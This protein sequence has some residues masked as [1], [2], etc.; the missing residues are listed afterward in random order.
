M[1]QICFV[2]KDPCPESVSLTKYICMTVV[3]FAPLNELPAYTG[4]GFE[5]PQLW[6]YFSTRNRL[7]ETI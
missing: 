6:R 3:G 1:V 5:P 4:A 2:L 7:N